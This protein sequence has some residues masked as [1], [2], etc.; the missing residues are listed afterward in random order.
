MNDYKIILENSALNDMKKIIRYIEE[1][2][3]EPDTAVNFY[4]N[5]IKVINSLNSMPKRNRVIDRDV[6]AEVEFR[7]VF[8]N[9]YTAFYYVN[10]ADLTVHIVRVL[11]TSQNWIQYLE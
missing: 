4:N 7:R 2:L 1:D 11:H 3:T 9:S 5:A 6:V 10:D 8:I